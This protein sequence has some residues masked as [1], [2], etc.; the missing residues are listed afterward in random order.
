MIPNCERYPRG[1]ALISGNFFIINDVIELIA[2]A[3]EVT[4]TFSL[5][6]ARHVGLGQLWRQA[7]LGEGAHGWLV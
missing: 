3:P 6:P 4:F 1:W 5:P 7:G 2:R